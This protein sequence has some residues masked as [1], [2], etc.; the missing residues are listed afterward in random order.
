MSLYLTA[1]TGGVL[2]RWR[3]WLQHKVGGNQQRSADTRPKRQRTHSHW[4]Q[5][6]Y[7]VFRQNG[8]IQSDR[9]EFL[10][11]CSGGVHPRVWS[12]LTFQSFLD[13]SDGLCA[14][15]KLGWVTEISIFRGGLSALGGNL[16]E[17]I[18]FRWHNRQFWVFYI[19]N[20]IDFVCKGWSWWRKSDIA[21]TD[22]NS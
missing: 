21:L 15:C 17:K 1:P 10:Q 11:C 18:N 3:A 7:A 13:F 8:L 4:S 6:I 9:A 14:W 5:G 20:C 19:L 22:Q 12:V 16:V 2:V